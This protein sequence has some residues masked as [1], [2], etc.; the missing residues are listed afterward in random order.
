MDI[1]NLLYIL[2]GDYAYGFLSWIYDFVDVIN[3]ISLIWSLA[4]C[5]FGWKLFKVCLA[6]QGSLSA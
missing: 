5:Y 1:L 4:C 3:V 2:F 6:F